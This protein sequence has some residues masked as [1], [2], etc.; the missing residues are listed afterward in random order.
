[1]NVTLV[2]VQEDGVKKP[3]P[4]K[5]DRV[6]IGRKP[7]ASIRVPVSSVSREHCELVLAG[8]RL[9]V[10]DL[11]SSNGT[12]VN[13]SRVQEAELKAGD[14]LSVGPAVFVAVIDGVPAEIDGK[15]TY[16]KGKSPEPAAAASAPAAR[17]ASP[18]AKTSA[19]ASAAK[20]TAKPA[21]KPAAKPS[22]LDDELDTSNLDDSSVSDFD[23]DFLDEDEE[24]KKKL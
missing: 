3:V 13:R 18:S 8:G 17:P 12:Y 19:P 6:V 11:G 4:M 2:L 7:E 22:S 20:P 16:A 1:V 5:R 9:T 15:E 24:D 14:V 23:F 10:R 21:A